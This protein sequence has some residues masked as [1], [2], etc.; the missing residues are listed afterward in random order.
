MIKYHIMGTCTSWSIESYKVLSLN[1][2]DVSVTLV[3][4]GM[5]TKSN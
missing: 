4:L 2:T 1:L 3:T 5:H